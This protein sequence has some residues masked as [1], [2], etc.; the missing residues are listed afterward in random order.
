MA[1]SIRDV[2]GEALAELGA[3]YADIVVLDADLSGSTKSKV[4]G[5][6][7]PDRFFN[8][9]IAE[10]DMVSCAAGLATTGKIPFVNTFT[11]FLTTLGL[12]ATRAQVCYGNLNVKL[13]GGYC[14]MSDALDGATHHATEDI[15]VMRSLPNMQVIVPADPEATR[16]ATRYAVEHVGPV[17]LRLSRGEY[18]DLYPAGTKFE[19]GKGKVVREGKDCTVF[20]IGIMVHKALEAAELLK[21]EGIELEVVDLVS[22]KPIDRA[23][24]AASAKKTGAVVCAEEHQIYGGAGSAVAEVLAG[25]GV[26][27]PTEFIGIQDTFT[28]TGKYDGLMETY[29]LDAKAVAQAAKRAIA[30]K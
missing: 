12:I 2:Y 18:P 6:K 4:F 7:Y 17:Y 14:G 27:A 8:M 3:E 24:I 28:E 22:V 23:L 13:A 21:A 5:Q 26:G 25:E 30:R 16:W 15:A 19:A 10:S 29:G 9:G 11:V 20:A 1:K